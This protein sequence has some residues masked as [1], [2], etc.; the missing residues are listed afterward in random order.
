VNTQIKP[1]QLAEAQLA[2][3]GDRQRPVRR[4]APD[5]HI[6]TQLPPDPRHDLVLLHAVPA[7]LL[8]PSLQKP[9]QGEKC[10]IMRAIWRGRHRKE[11]D[12]DREGKERSTEHGC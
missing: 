9:A 5:E 4:V 10:G 2:R 7:R 3:R 1:L 11:H 8:D 12:I 6:G